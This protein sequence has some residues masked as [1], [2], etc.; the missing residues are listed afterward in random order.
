MTRQGDVP[1]GDCS[2]RPGRGVV[3]AAIAL[4]V[5]GG[6]VGPA[7]VVQ[8]QAQRYRLEAELQPGEHRLS[9]RSSLN[10]AV[11]NRALPPDDPVTIELELHPSLRVSRVNA[12][13]ARVRGW[14]TVQVKSADGDADPS[15]H[16]R[17]V[18]DRPVPSLTLFV[19]YAGLLQEDLSAG[20]K[21]GEI[22]NFE[23][24]AH[25]GPEGVYLG[26]GSWY[27]RPVAPESKRPTLADFELLVPRISGMELVAGAERDAELSART[28]LLAWRTPY[29]VSHLVLVGGPHQIHERMHG[30]VLVRLH[31]KEDQAPQ[32]ETL[33][34]AVATNLDRY[35]PLLGPYPGGEY[36][37]VDNFFSSGFAFPLF[38]LLSS[39]VINMGPRMASSHGYLDHEMLHSWWGNGVHVDPADGNWCEALA[40]YGANYYGYI[41]DG[42]ETEARRIRR[43]YAH[44][45]SRLKPDEDKPLG[46]FGQ[47]DGCGRGVAY[48]KGAMVF[49]MLARK[50]GQENFWSAMRRLTDEYLGRYASWEDIRRL[51]EEAGGATLETFLAQWVRAS[52]APML[53]LRSAQYDSAESTLRLEL[54]QGDPPFALD[55][56]VRVTDADGDQ[57]VMVSFS[58]PSAVVPVKVRGI[59]VSVE[60]DPDFHVF[61]KVPPDEI[62]PTTATTRTGDALVTIRPQGELHKELASLQKTFE[63]SFEK[64]GTTATLTTGDI[65]EGA[66]A[67]SNVLILGAAVNDP[68]VSGFL[69]AIEFPVR[70]TERGFEFEG[71]SYE[72]PGDAL[73]CTVRHPDVLGGGITVVYAN[74]DEALPRANF[75]PFYDHSLVIFS[76]GMAKLR[77]DF[78]RRSAVAVTRP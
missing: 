5:A 8:V 74:S 13:G 73:L 55:V 72:Q 53:T 30:D 45:L 1:I 46:T 3:L 43:N 11:E 17:V 27:P 77:R 68:Y 16:I 29:P 7:P 32:A 67:G 76:N 60:V 44:F 78:E 41:L 9:G 64:D 51:C 31:L 61:R 10:L 39:A 62:I 4:S 23:V 52:G 24:D 48:Q 66:L 34:N 6:C 12:A 56:P 35:Q 70:W 42:N 22:H 40:S 54:Y 36:A 63:T 50:I 28:G 26:D 57:D 37:I 19:E 33:F 75:V 69:S 14:R 58:T 38:T 15:Q 25:V 20:E 59:P 2:R 49:H 71:Q 65:H 21:P 18:I 47:P